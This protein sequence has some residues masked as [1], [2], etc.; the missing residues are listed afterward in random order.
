MSALQRFVADFI[1]QTNL[2]EGTISDKETVILETE[3]M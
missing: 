3:N 2:L 1:G